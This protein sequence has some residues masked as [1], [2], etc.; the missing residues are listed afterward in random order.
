[1]FANRKEVNKLKNCPSEPKP[2]D[3]LMPAVTHLEMD[4]KFFFK[5]SHHSVF[6]LELSFSFISTQNLIVTKY[7]FFAAETFIDLLI[8]VSCKKIQKHGVSV[9]LR[10][11]RAYTFISMLICN[12]IIINIIE[13]H[14]TNS[15]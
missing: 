10:F 12:L 3:G 6:L 11:S 5:M 8:V 15:F 9:T 1:M 4:E 13:A 2:R 7:T 14:G